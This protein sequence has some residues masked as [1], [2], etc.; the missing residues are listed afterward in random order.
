M[1]IDLEDAGDTPVEVTALRGEIAD[2]HL[3]LNQMQERTHAFVAMLA[4]E[5]RTPLG[6]ILM[7]AHVLRMGKDSDREAAIEAIDVS[8]RAQSRLIGKLLD[9][10]RALTGRLRI[11]KVPV[12]LGAAVR[13]AA[14]DLT[15]AAS[16]AGVP[17]SLAIPNVPVHVR[18][19]AVRV[20]EIVAALIENAIRVS[21]S[22]GEVAV[23]VARVGENVRVTVRDAGPGL[24]PEEAG[25]LLTAF[26]VPDDVERRSPAALALE[27]P[28]A[29][30][31][32]ELHG[33]SV[34]H[35]PGSERGSTFVVELPVEPNGQ[36]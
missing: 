35:E 28:L 16:E 29:R 32:A 31:L 2:L 33:G 12:E 13:G 23:S 17:L 8:A 1:P 36:P 22:A 19:D 3:R 21:R 15:G 6:A 4:H 5:L 34:T 9:V 11:E 20:R 14:E 10:T 26:H 25:N 7:W 24:S 30:L 18:G 27:L